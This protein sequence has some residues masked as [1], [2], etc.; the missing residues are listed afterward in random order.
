[1]AVTPEDLRKVAIQFC[2]CA[3]E[4]IQFFSHLDD[5]TQH[6]CLDQHPEAIDIQYVMQF[7][8]MLIQHRVNW[9][10]LKHE[11]EQSVILTRVMAELFAGENLCLVPESQWRIL[12]A[13]TAGKVEY[14]PVPAPLPPPTPPGPRTPSLPEIDTRRGSTPQTVELWPLVMLVGPALIAAVLIGAWLLR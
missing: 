3:D 1:M 12:Q 9:Q 8:K 2:G 14:A 5:F 7:R 6:A 10:G 13:A 4:A 11:L